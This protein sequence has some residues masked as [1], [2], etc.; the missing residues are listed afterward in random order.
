MEGPSLLGPTGLP[1]DLYQTTG[2]THWTPISTHIWDPIGQE[3]HE[4][5]ADLGKTRLEMA[6][7]VISGQVPRENV[8]SM[9]PNRRRS[10]TLTVDG[11]VLPFVNCG[12]KLS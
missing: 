9:T 6:T 12:L 2:A 7:R 4:R 3:R 5:H 11:L 8:T 1:S 10:I